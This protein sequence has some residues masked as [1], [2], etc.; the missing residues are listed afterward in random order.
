M[1]I[2][3]Q[4]A[5]FVVEH[6]DDELPADVAHH[7]KRVVLD[8]LGCIYGGFD[9]SSA[10]A[11]LAALPKMDPG[12]AATLFGRTERAG[13]GGAIL[14]NGAML[15]YLDLNDMQY[16]F[17][18]PGPGPHNSEILAPVLA[19]AEIGGRDGSAVLKALSLGY[20]LST[21]FV[22]GVQG[23]SLAKRG[24]MSDIRATFATPPVL[25]YLLGASAREIVDAIG[26]ACLRQGPLGVAD[27]GSEENTLAKNL[28]FP[29][30]AYIGACSFFLAQAG[31]NGPTN[32]LEGEG[33]F[34]EVIVNGEYDPAPLTS[35]YVQHR[36]R[37]TVMK[38]FAACY[39][40]HAHIEATIRLAD[41]NDI[42]P[43]E[44]VA[45]D[46]STTSRTNE[47][48]GRLVRQEPPPNKETADHSSYY[49]TAVALIDR[50][51]GPAQYTPAKLTDPEVERLMRATTC[52]AE[53]EFDA[54]YP[55]SEVT[56]HTAGRGSFTQRVE[57]PGGSLLDPLTDAEIEAKFDALAAPYASSE[58]RKRVINLVWALDTVGDIGELTGLL[59]QRDSA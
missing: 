37:E 7:A 14:Y 36:L 20:D 39:G 3:E 47:H 4:V 54:R 27:I 51:V 35:D 16:S 30:G 8:T 12:G 46:V 38:K 45:V 11:V 10:A 23:P 44:V 57:Q 28:R 1:S 49:L 18:R 22:D 32:V 59:Q 55:C 53:P 19:A 15:R 43:D 58:T 31:M 13:L 34:A 40:T 5:Q 24:W 56:I 29:F 25:G 42:Q 33:G 41:D 17:R 21:A 48:N 6:A 52:R 9:S 2:T 50:A 26:M